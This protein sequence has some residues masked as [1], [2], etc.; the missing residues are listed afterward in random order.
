M[1]QPC[2]EAPGLHRIGQCADRQRF[3]HWWKRK[4]N[5]VM[6]WADLHR[7][8][9]EER[10]TP[11]RT[12]L[13]DRNKKPRRTKY[14]VRVIMKEM[15]WN[16]LRFKDDGGRRE[17][18]SW[19]PWMSAGL[20]MPALAR[21]GRHGMR[22]ADRDSKGDRSRVVHPPVDVWLAHASRQCAI[23]SRVCL[24]GQ[25]NKSASTKIGRHATGAS[26]ADARTAASSQVR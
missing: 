7:Y 20:A 25:Q 23:P 17:T 4:P 16:N 11:M 6:R 14:M 22:R 9:I 10:V 15:A 5:L 13:K 19:D 2:R 1:K 21:D 3:H 12:S 8:S 24:V 18:W 26:R